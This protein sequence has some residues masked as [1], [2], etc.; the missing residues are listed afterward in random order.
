[1]QQARAAGLGEAAALRM[2]RAGGHHLG[3]APLRVARPA[4]RVS[5]QTARAPP[6]YVRHSAAPGARAQARAPA[7]R[8]AAHGSALH[9]G[10]MALV[11]LG[12]ELLAALAV[13]EQADTEPK[14][15]VVRA[16]PR[17]PVLREPAST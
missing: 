2:S 7:P 11:S 15:R 13:V 9:R 10:P 5:A 6:F 4:C 1:M 14:N 17:A 16:A 8:V 12:D 3:G